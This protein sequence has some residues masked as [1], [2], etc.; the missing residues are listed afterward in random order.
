[1]VAVETVSQKWRLE[2]ETLEASHAKEVKELKAK[3]EKRIM[4]YKDGMDQANEGW[5]A[6]ELELTREREGHLATLTD[7]R[8]C[9]DRY[10]EVALRGRCDH[11]AGDGGS[12]S[13][14]PSRPTLRLLHTE[15]ESSARTAELLAEVNEKTNQVEE[16]QGEVEA[17]RGRNR[18]LQ[19]LVSLPESPGAVKLD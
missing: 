7:Y 3:Y 9:H 19:Q 17:L 1:M 4:A 11:Q 15:S 13:L 10:D 6:V 18:E 2:V 16:L 14:T 12:S 5:H 8:K